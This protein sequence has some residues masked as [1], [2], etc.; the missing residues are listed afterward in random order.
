MPRCIGQR[1]WCFNRCGAT[2]ALGARPDAICELAISGVTRVLKL[3]CVRSD[4]GWRTQGIA[5]REDAGCTMAGVRNALGA[6]APRADAGSFGGAG[7]GA[8][9]A[10][11]AAAAAAAAIAMTTD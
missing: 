1:I 8:A 4:P 5:V 11:A 3:L 6:A 10:A 9:N 7:G 2:R